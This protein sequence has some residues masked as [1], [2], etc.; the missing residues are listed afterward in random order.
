M[1]LSV[2]E[3]SEALRL[4]RTWNGVSLAECERISGIR[5]DVISKWERGV[6]EPSLSSLVRL[7][8]SLGRDFGD[9]QRAINRLRTANAPAEKREHDPI[10]GEWPGDEED[11]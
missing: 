11:T 9:L 2:D 10:F 3:I 8:Q 4:I 6:V 1:S 5:K 7:L